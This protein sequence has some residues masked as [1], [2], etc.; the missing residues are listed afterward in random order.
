MRFSLFK[1]RVLCS[2][3]DIRISEWSLQ[4]LESLAAGLRV[5]CASSDLVGPTWCTTS[6]KFLLK[7]HSWKHEPIQ[8][9]AHS[10]SSHAPQRLVPSQLPVVLF[11]MCAKGTSYSELADPGGRKK[12]PSLWQGVVLFTFMSQACHERR[13]CQHSAHPRSGSNRTAWGF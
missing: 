11:L 6:N 5:F 4:H 3:I 2:T 8:F 9:Q 10:R 13:F 7:I 12:I 1:C